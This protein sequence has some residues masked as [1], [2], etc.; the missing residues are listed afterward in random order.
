[1]VAKLL[2]LKEEN[3]LAIGMITMAVGLLIGQ[4]SRFEYAGVLG[5]SVQ[6][7]AQVTECHFRFNRFLLN[8]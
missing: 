3:L 1:M 8:P 2:R 6:K 4:F 5:L 7:T